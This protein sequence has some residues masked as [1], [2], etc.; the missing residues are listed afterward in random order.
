MQIELLNDLFKEKIKEIIKN[1]KFFE[2]NTNDSL[3]FLNLYTVIDNNELVGFFALY[4]NESGLN[5]CYLYVMPKF[6]RKNYGYRI[7]NEITEKY[8][9][10][11]PYIYLSVNA[12]NKIALK[13]YESYP[14]YFLHKDRKTLIQSK[15]FLK[16]KNQLYKDGNDYEAILYYNEIAYQKYEKELFNILNS[17]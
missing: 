11:Y 2:Y 8:S 5:V 12:D 14:G 15:N 4:P 17:F 9:K 1:E 13:L 16:Y 7:L 6:R 10:D 3:E